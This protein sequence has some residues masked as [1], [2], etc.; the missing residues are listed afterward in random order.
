MAGP[1]GQTEMTKS[2]LQVPN[3]RWLADTD[4]YMQ[5]GQKPA[6]PEVFLASAATSRPGPWTDTPNTFWHD[7]YWTFIGKIWRGERKAKDILPELS[8]LINET[9]RENNPDGRK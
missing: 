6:H 7:V 4:V 2:G 9:L 1:E 8:P 3:Q 5:R